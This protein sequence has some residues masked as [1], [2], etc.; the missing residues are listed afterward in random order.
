MS[1]TVL[2]LYQSH[3]YPAMSHPACDPATTAV[4]AK[5][6]GLT[7]PP[8]SCARILEI[9]CSSGHNL[10]PLAQRW[11]DSQFIGI[12]FSPAAIQQARETARLAGIENIEF[13]EADLRNYDPGEDGFDFILAHGFYSWVPADIRQALV[14]FCARHL[15]AEGIATISYNTLPGWKQR[16]TVVDLV[17]QLAARPVAG[18]IGQDPAGILAY[19][20]TIPAG[21]SPDAVQ[22]NSVLHDMFAKSADILAF[23]DFGPVNHPVTFTGFISHTHAAGLRYLG[24]SELHANFPLSLP[25]GAAEALAPL[26]GDPLMLQQTIDVLTNRTFRSS[27]LC[28]ADA[29]V[30]TRLTTATALHFAV[31]GLHTFERT[32]QGGRLVDHEGKEQGQFEHPLAVAFFSALAATSPE[33]VPM[34]EI[35]ERVAAIPAA[36]FDPTVSLPPIARLVMDAARQ[37]LIE[38]R[39]EPVRFDGSI[40][41]TPKFD[42]LRQLAVQRQQ[43][44][45]DIYHAPCTVPDSRRTVVRAMDGTRTVEELAALAHVDH[46]RLDVR[47]WLAHLAARGLF[48]K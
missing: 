46:P 27:L 34:Q 31:R 20:A 39:I 21:D 9:G 14:D 25:P 2:D 7:V 29:P 35:L 10:L 24:E 6:A 13:H 22:L 43:A 18:T 37:K 3:S 42:T 12:D 1:D 45:V 38:L 40:P 5:L 19:L 32:P 28:R 16:Q 33:A 26:A 11:P 44:L 36:Q 47:A 23:D 48:V 4:A 8:P 17:R 15:T 30:D 41:R